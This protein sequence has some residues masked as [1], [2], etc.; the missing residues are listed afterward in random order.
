MDGEHDVARPA[1]AAGQSAAAARLPG[2]TAHGA[3]PVQHGA[4]GPGGRGAAPTRP[5]A[6]RVHTGTTFAPL[7]LDWG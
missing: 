1:A 3:G 7:Y 6:R 5:P 2:E 4:P